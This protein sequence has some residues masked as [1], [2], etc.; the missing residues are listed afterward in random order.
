MFSNQ[1]LL[2]IKPWTVSVPTATI[3]GVDFL[4]LVPKFAKILTYEMIEVDVRV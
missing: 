1:E 4:I 2:S 3:R